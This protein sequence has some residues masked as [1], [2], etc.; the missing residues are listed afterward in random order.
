MVG[1]LWGSPIVATSE[2]LCPASPSLQW[3]AWAYLPHLSGQPHCTV[4][5]Y[6]DPLRLANASLRFVHSSLS[7]PDTFPMR[8]R[9]HPDLPSSRVTPFENMPGSQTPA[10]TWTLAIARPG[11]LSSAACIAST[12]VLTYQDLSHGTTIIHFS[13][14][15]TEPETS[16]HPAS[17]SRYRICPW[18][19]LM[20]CWLYVAHV[21]LPQIPR[22][23]AEASPALRF[24]A[25]S[26]LPTARASPAE[27]CIVLHYVRSPTG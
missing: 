23:G 8:A 6:Y 20:N 26:I 17:D 24:T 25:K 10:V 7:A 3:V 1:D 2:T 15:N 19:S 21:G 12:F 18:T 27:R 14:L 4:H 5:R 16:L 11:L 22:L 9:P 13:G